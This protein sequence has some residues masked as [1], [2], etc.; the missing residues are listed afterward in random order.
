MAEEATLAEEEQRVTGN[1]TKK[2]LS[3]IVEAIILAEIGTTGE[4]RVHL[5]R[6]WLEK[7]PYHRATRLFRHFKMF[8]TKDRNAVLLYFNLRRKKFAIIGDTG[9]HQAVGQNYWS[10]LSEKLRLDLRGTHPEKAIALAVIELGK[11]LK[12]HFPT[13]NT[14]GTRKSELKDLKIES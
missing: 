14:E 6:N 2:Q 4:I 7:N 8:Q 10:N 5:S 9:V 13:K 12:K 3:P 1:P 11:T